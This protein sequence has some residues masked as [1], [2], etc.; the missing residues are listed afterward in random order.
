[1]TKQERAHI[2]ITELTRLYPHPAPSLQFSNDWELVVAVALSAQTTDKQV[3]KV[4]TELFKKYPTLDHYLHADLETFRKDISSIG[5]YKS[6]AKNMLA[7]A[8]I[9]DSVFHRKTPKTIKELMMLPGVGRKTANVV[10]GNAHGI[11]E[12]IAVDTHV[13]RL[14]QKFQLTKNS[15][16]KKIEQDLITII[17]QK[18]WFLF[19]VRMIEYGREHSPARKVADNSD[20]IS[21]ILVS[22]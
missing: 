14:S 9:Y 15:D 2:V 5:L 22:N 4:T 7:A 13:T 10:L 19:T 21:K 20:P 6:K 11:A 3:N 1:M 16:P 8:K 18:E 12:G 17:P